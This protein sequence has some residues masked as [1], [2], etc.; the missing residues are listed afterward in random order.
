MGRC[1]VSDRAELSAAERDA[2]TALC[3][4]VHP[5]L[6]HYGGGPCATCTANVKAL[7]DLG[8]EIVKRDEYE[9]IH[10]MLASFQQEY[11]GD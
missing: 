11:E 7:G 9:A 5:A 1:P 8:Y 3:D 4:N 6:S 10:S 2:A